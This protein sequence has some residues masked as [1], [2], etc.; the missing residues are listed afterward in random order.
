MANTRQQIV[1]ELVDLVKNNLGSIEE[2]I[3]EIKKENGEGGFLDKI[4][5]IATKALPIL[6]SA[7]HLF[8]LP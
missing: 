7:R 4:I 8:G 3:A 2:I 6:L 5:P 1:N